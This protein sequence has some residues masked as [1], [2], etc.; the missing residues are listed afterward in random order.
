MWE[1]CQGGALTFKALREGYYWLTVKMDYM[2]YAHKCDKCQRFA[3]ISKAHLEEL[4]S[5]T[6]LCLFV[7]QVI[8]LIGRLPKGRGSAQYV[9]VAVDY[10]TKWVKAKALASIML[11][12]IKKFV[13]KN[14]VCRYGVPH[15]IV[16]N[17][18]TQFDCNKFKE[19]YD[20]LQIKKVF[21]LVMPPQANG[22]VKV[23]N[24]TIKHNL[25]T[26]LRNLKGR[27][28]DNLSEVLQAYRTTAGV[29]TRETLLS[30]A[31]GYEAMV[32][33]ELGA[34]FLR[35][36][37]FD[38]EQNMILQRVSLI[39]LKKNSATH[40]FESRHMNDA[41]LDTSTQS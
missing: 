7:G 23:V 36:D 37:N 25:K 35:R 18:G 20:D 2:E 15:T 40:N 41:L 1:P 11:A 27:W 19:F 6:S 10:F 12:K 3:L 8:D 9:G 16:S 17:N 39:F 21:S 29:T 38:L 32:P 24:K 14:I 33:V 22:Q 34:G 26:K 5:M 31:Y 28:V 13:Y 4:T 30:L